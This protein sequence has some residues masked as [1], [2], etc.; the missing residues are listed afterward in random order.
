LVQGKLTHNLLDPLQART[1][2]D[3]TQQL[4]DR[5]NLQVHTGISCQIFFHSTIIPP[6]RVSWVS[7]EADNIK[8]L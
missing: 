7:R 4:A 6:W 8:E 1:L 3:M 2:I 5:H